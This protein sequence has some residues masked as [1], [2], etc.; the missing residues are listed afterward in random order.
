MSEHVVTSQET[1]ADR[2]A[3]LKH[4]PEQRWLLGDAVA[5]SYRVGRLL[6]A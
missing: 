6:L 5:E 2:L 3:K 4:R 1:G